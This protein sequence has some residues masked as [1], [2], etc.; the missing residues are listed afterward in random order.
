MPALHLPNIGGELDVTLAAADL[1]LSS[2]A[3]EALGA[4]AAPDFL[5]ICVDP[6]GIR[7]QPEWMKVTA[8]T[9]GAGTA[10]VT[11]AQ[12][13]STARIH[14]AKMEWVHTLAPSEV[15]ALALKPWHYGIPAELEPDATIGSWVFVDHGSPYVNGGTGISN[16][17]G[18]QNDEISWDLILEAG[19]WDVIFHHRRSTNVGIYT[20]SLGGVTIG[21]VDGYA[22]APAA[23][24][25]SILGAVVATTGKKRLTFKMA[26]KNPSSSAYVGTL[27]FVTVRRSA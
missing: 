22:A 7:G 20:V 26:T 6:D 4:I 11:R 5:W 13:G 16:G 10:T 19:T 3:L 12:E 14:K 15:D 18:T 2:P 24:K 9:S 27:Q 23:Q 1:T 25:S 17:A 21:T 8:H